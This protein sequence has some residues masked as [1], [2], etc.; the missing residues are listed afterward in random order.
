MTIVHALYSTSV[1]P[2]PFMCAN[3]TQKSLGNSSV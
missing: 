1:V 2:K 3:T